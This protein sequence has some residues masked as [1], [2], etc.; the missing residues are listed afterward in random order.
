MIDCEGYHEHEEDGKV[1]YMPCKSHEQVD[2]EEFGEDED[3]SEWTLI[4][5][6]KVDYDNEEA[7]DYQ[8]DELNKNNKNILPQALFFPC[9]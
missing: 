8:I 4:D 3:L 5:E 2:L 9:M 6:R 1:W 7:L